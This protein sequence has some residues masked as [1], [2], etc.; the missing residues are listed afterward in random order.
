[1]AA[2]IL[3]I[4]LL[5]S[6]L[7]RDI[8][9]ATATPVLPSFVTQDRQR[10]STT[11]P[12][13]AQTKLSDS[14]PGVPLGPPGNSPFIFVDG[15]S[16]LFEFQQLNIYP[17]SCQRGIDCVLT[18]FGT[19]L[20]NPGALHLHV[21]AKNWIAPESE[22]EPF[23]DDDFCNDWAVVVQDGIVR[24]PPISGFTAMI[25]MALGGFTLDPYDRD[26]ELNITLEVHVTAGEETVL[27]VAGDVYIS[28][29]F[30][31]G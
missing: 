21:D 6:L 4:A 13:G 15:P 12:A 16:D 26:K 10:V 25:S 9:H 19:F 18:A 11:L 30:D 3:S 17:P 23:I 14:A 31:Q 7:G 2:T 28:P 24:C 22:P 29:S 20:Q 27:H 5:T 8:G 1:M